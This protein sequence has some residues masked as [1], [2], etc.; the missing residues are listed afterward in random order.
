M[1]ER[2]FNGKF[3]VWQS[4]HI[5]RELCEH[6][7][8]AAIIIIVIIKGNTNISINF[9]CF[10]FDDDLL[11][12][13]DVFIKSQEDITCRCKCIAKIISTKLKKKKKPF[14]VCVSSMFNIQDDIVHESMHNMTQDDVRP[15]SHSEVINWK[16]YARQTRI[17]T[18][19][20]GAGC[21]GWQ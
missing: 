1:K 9:C 2:K 7:M 5:T 12:K 13:V 15:L 17:G 16:I 6:V 14:H 21:G 19:K 18:K 4:L 3:F 10:G 11:K 20:F 8:V